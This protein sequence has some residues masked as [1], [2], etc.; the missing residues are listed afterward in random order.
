MELQKFNCP[1]KPQERE[2]DCGRGGW[3]WSVRF[4]FTVNLTITQRLFR[5]IILLEIV[6]IHDLA[7]A[8]ACVSLSPF[9]RPANSR[10]VPDYYED[11]DAVAIAA[12]L[13]KRGWENALAKTN[14]QKE[15]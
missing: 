14:R 4:Y 13:M 3:S 5:I 9:C 1:A 7:R 12:A 2:A 10:S 6:R 11:A 8:D 15:L